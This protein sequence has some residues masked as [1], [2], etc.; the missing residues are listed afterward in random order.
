M[1]WSYK[2]AAVG[3]DLHV[4]DVIDIS[5]RLILPHFYCSEGLLNLH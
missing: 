3:Q 4:D 2:D 5:V 1:K